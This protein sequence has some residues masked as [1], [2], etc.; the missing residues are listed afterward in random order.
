[1]AQIALLIA[2]TAA[3]TEGKLEQGRVA[4]LEADTS[5]AIAEFNAEQLEREGRS[6]REASK[7]EVRR[8][9]R[10]E[11]ITSGQEITRFGKSG[12]ALG[13]GTPI[14][15]LADTVEQF[16]IGRALTARKGLLDEQRLGAAARVQRLQGRFATTRGK[17]IRKSAILSAAGSASQLFGGK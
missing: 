11:K 3:S 12:V 4:K 7:I 9:T 15:V 1:M 16:A 10:Q 2:G 8:I 17:A 6:R 13:E 14:G 5:A